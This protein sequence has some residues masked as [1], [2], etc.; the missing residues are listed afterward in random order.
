MWT[1]RFMRGCSKDPDRGEQL[2]PYDLS[3]IQFLIFI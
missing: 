3:C 2:F 1:A